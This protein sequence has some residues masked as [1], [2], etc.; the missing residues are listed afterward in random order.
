[1]TGN[2]D[3]VITGMTDKITN[4]LIEIQIVHEMETKEIP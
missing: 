3:T 1:M 4:I 2:T